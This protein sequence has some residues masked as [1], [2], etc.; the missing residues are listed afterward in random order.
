MKVWLLLCS[1]LP[2]ARRGE[3]GSILILAAI[4][5]VVIIGSAGL[6]VDV[7]RMYAARAELSRAVD[8]AA[9][10]GVLDFDGTN[11]GLTKAQTTAQDYITANEPSANSS[12]VAS[13]ATNKMTINA[14]K[15]VKLYFLS[16]FGYNS[17]S[18]YGH[19]VAGFQ[20]QTIDAA[21]VIDSTGS[22]AGTSI[23]NAKS[24]ANNFTNVLLGS[25]PSGNVVVGIVPFRGCNRATSPSATQPWA[26]SQSL[27][28]SQDSEY[29]ALT[30]TSATLSSRIN[31]IC[32]SD[33]CV[34]GSGTNVCTGV[35]KGWEVLEGA[36]NHTATANNRRYMVVLSDGDNRYT[37]SYTY[38]TTPYDSPHTYQTKP[39]RP[40]TSCVNVGGD[41]IGECRSSVYTGAALPIAS[42]GFDTNNFTGGSGWLAAWTQ[43]NTPQTSSSNT[44]AGA[45]KAVLNSTDAISRGVNLGS[46]E[47]ANLTYYL[48]TG[49]AGTWSTSDRVYVETSPDNSSWT[50]RA[51]YGISGSG[52]TVINST[53]AQFTTSLSSLVGDSTS[54][55]RFRVS[56]SGS[57][58][59]AY[60]DTVAISDPNTDSTGYINGDDGSA[61][62]GASVK[63]ERQLDMETRDMATA[64]KADGVEIFV[65]AFGVCSN[66]TNYI[67]TSAECTGSSGASYIGNADADSTADQRLLKCIASSASGTLDHYFYAANA[68]DLPNIFTTIAAN[69]AHRLV[70]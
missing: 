57:T 66:T 58:V 12:V 68:S 35:A 39:C 22:M 4:S 48:R 59:S 54:Y 37:G 63:R 43:A 5:A 40:P 1:I 61:A 18:V 8:S 50:I 62:C 30:S 41:T 69:I 55:I 2:Q 17:A 44:Q 45:D 49:G 21:M 23:N 70:E 47:G 65:V 51:T 32:P 6:A 7:S 67:P 3:R 25:S 42:D 14:S 24:A 53:Y 38:Q 9:L 60:L 31:S 52:Q 13:G 64:A 36:G 16:L 46:V 19:A 26:N 20:N 29:T 15:A 11:A 33:N 27:C 34:G 56:T 28:V 10:A